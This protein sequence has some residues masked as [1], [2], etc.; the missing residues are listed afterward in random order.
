MRKRRPNSSHH[1]AATL[2]E[3]VR[4]GVHLR[5]IAGRAFGLQSPV[6]VYA[7]TLYVDV[8]FPHGGTLGVPPEHAE[9]AVHVVSGDVRVDGTVVPVGQMLVLAPGI[10]VE[11]A[12]SGA[13]RVLLCGGAPLDGPR[14]L[15]WNFVSSSRDR[16]ERAKA[17]W[18]AQRFGQVPGESDFIPLPER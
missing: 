10:E 12:A 11:V 15:W 18:Q 1:E 5:V 9:R 3:A 4:D 13:A 8:D 6:R 17:D 14:F 7:P 16:I 2:P